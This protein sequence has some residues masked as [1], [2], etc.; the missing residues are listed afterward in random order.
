MIRHLVCTMTTFL[1]LAVSTALGETG[2]NSIVQRNWYEIRTA[3][4][5]IYSCG[6]TQEVSRISARLEQFREAYSALAGTNAVASPPIVVM[7]FP[8]HKSMEPFLPLYQGKPVNLAA[9]FHRGSDE[10]LIVLA[11]SGTG[12]DSLEV[13]FHEYTHLLLRRND[14]IWPLW[15]KEG[16]AEIYSTFEASGRGAHIGRPIDHHLHLL[17]QK[18]FMSLSDLFAVAHDSSQYNEREHQGIFYAESWLLTHYLMLGDNPAHKAHFSQLTTLLRQGQTPAQAFT[19]AFR[20]TLPAMEAQL[21]RYLERGKF[22]SLALAVNADLSAPRAMTRRSIAPVE[23]C[24]YLGNELLRIDRLEPAQKYFE[25]AQ[26]FAPTSPLPFEGLGLLA[27]ERKKSDEAVRQLRESLQH[28]SKSFLAHY[29]FAK[30][31]FHLTADS[32]ERYTTLDKELATEIRTE[33]LKS[34]ALMPDFG[35][36]HQLLG[37][38][39]MVQGEDL[40]AAEQHLR[41]S[42]QL[43]PENQWYLLA[44]A[45]AQMA[46]K[47]SDGARHTLE[48]LR[49]PYVEA[50]L[51]A[52]AEEL[53]QEIGR[54][55]A[56]KP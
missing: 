31:R 14:R 7:A 19:N 24:F 5:N 37:F 36:A 25:Q 44:L 4:F 3:H 6:S 51:R 9:F 52:H 1:L 48:P 47:N 38:F 32:K 23:T 46:Q 11:L 15:L 20:T 22:E 12:S 16:M 8:D 30:E 2:G 39:E 41:K 26:K 34:I 55:T 53:I 49:L 13:I 27:A 56:N 18:P 45:Q 10:N 33:L 42:V 21:R 28:G 50:K 29:T 17:G 40:A 54:P 43:E 35:P